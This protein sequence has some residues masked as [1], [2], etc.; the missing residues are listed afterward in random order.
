MAETPER[1]ESGDIDAFI[2]LNEYT[3]T[4]GE[5]IEIPKMGWYR[6][7]EVTKLLSSILSDCPS[8]KMRDW[9]MDLSINVLLP[10]ALEAI[11]TTPDRVTRV[12]V[13][14]TKRKPEWCQELDPEDLVG[15]LI[16]FY[17]KNFTGQKDL[18]E[19]VKKSLFT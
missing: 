15:I 5:K 3:T 10:F 19:R 6:L 4:T 1:S 16:P 17:R 8:F 2:N 18:W 7:A 9:N 14:I 11:Q 12:L 13:L